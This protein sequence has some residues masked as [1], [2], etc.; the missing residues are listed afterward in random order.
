[1]DSKYLLRSCISRSKGW[2]ASSCELLQCTQTHPRAIPSRGHTSLQKEASINMHNTGYI[3]KW[4]SLHHQLARAGEVAFMKSSDACDVSC[5]QKSSLLKR[6]Q[7]TD[8]IHS[9]ALTS[10]CPTLSRQP[11]RP[12]R[13]TFCLSSG[14]QLLKDFFGCELSKWSAFSQHL[15]RLVIEMDLTNHKIIKA[16]AIP[17]PPSQALLSFA[18]FLPLEHYSRHEKV[19]CAS[20]AGP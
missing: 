9:Q 2:V 17:R 12:R 5:F 10:A 11:C 8:A 3:Q 7:A 15:S 18:E 14:C 1:M 16:V 6:I 13:P 20:N 4:L 19:H